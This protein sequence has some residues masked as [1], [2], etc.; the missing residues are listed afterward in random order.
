MDFSVVIPTRNRPDM[1]A[2][3][4]D[5]VLAQSHASAEIIV[6]DDGSEEAHRRQVRALCARHSA[7]CALI[8]L[9]RRERGH[10]PS[11]ARNTGI[12]RARGH[13][14]CF[15]DDDD[16]WTDPEHLA[17]ALR[18]ARGDGT[19]FDLY[20]ANQAAYRDGHKV[21]GAIWLE[22]L[23][24]DLKTRAVPDANGCYPV[25]V[26]ELLAQGGFCHL[27]TT[28]ISR[29][30]CER[31]GG[32]DESLR[33]EEDR[34]FYLRSIQ[35]ATSIRYAPSFVSRHNIPNPKQQD[36]ASTAISDLEKHLMQ[37]RVLDKAIMLS[38]DE[39][40]RAYAMRHKR[41]V[42]LK[43]S[44]ACRALGRSGAARYYRWEAIGAG[45]GGRGRL[46]EVWAMLRRAARR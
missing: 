45:L 20:L 15:L 11:F 16:W 46:A 27:N 23:A 32:F 39:G 31:I 29:S 10:G 2:A 9:P 14:L 44:D 34:D 7:G 33:Y 18:C 13:Y 19:G 5:S 42:L 4:V 3:A 38:D 40:I 36:S 43:V 12:G 6:V 30:L 22:S 1:L 21:Q 8:E 35:G 26:A 25:S 28:I 41:W 24:S 37:L 17:R